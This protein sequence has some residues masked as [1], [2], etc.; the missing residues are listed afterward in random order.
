[1]LTYTAALSA[2][3]LVPAE[4]GPDRSRDLHNWNGDIL[5]EHKAP[6]HL[7]TCA[8]HFSI[9]ICGCNFAIRLGADSLQ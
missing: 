4:R 9:L 2:T 5:S 6:F 3:G 1:M 8:A 7:F